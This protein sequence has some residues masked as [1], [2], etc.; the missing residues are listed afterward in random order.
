MQGSQN[1]EGLVH[2]TH[3]SSRLS[4]SAVDKLYLAALSTPFQK[5][6]FVPVS[7]L[8]YQPF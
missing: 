1:D 4:E 7:D 2:V 5:L 3:K 8:Y 6:P